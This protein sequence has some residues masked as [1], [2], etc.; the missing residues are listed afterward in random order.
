MKAKIILLS[1]ISIALV[2]GAA[3]HLLVN[4]TKRQ[5]IE[6]L[7]DSVSRATSLYKYINAAETL[8]R[9]RAAEEIAARKELLDVLVP[10][11]LAANPIEAEQKIQVEL[12]VINK[13][14]DPSDVLFITDTEGRVVAKNLDN[15]LKGI[16]F[17]ENLLISN[18]ISGR[19]D[20]DIFEILGKRMKVVSVPIR[21]EG[22]IIGT[23]NS[24]N[25]IDSEMAKGDFSN[26]TEETNEEKG[27]NPLLFAFVEKQKVLGSTMP[28]ELH[29]ALKKYIENNPDIVE[30]ALKEEERKH[31]FTAKLNGEK[32]YANIAVHEHLGQEKY[33]CYLFVSS[34]DKGLQPLYASRNNFLWIV[35]IVLIIAIIFGIV[36]EEQSQAP[37]SRFT[38][39]MI[40]IIHGNRKFRFSN[41][42]EGVEGQ[43]NQNA[44]MM[45]AA[46]LGERL[47]DEKSGTEKI[48]V[49]K[50][51]E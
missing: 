25:I 11:A 30:K 34:I 45:I 18:A 33:V 29:E 44:N 20:E 10:A 7:E 12:N 36:I 5:L 9:I 48:G 42:A 24:A 15:T 46:L 19:S 31:A 3:Y 28:P 41:E 16:S 49:M 37:I 43:L 40:E 21:K 1:V 38:E 50:P 13:F 27:N 22:A 17:K 39:G 8:D 2:F 32:F 6:T 14:S 35:I 51:E 47:P 26:L 23:F 4:Q